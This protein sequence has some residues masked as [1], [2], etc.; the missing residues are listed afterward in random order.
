MKLRKK[1]LITHSN[2]WILDLQVSEKS[3]SIANQQLQHSNSKLADEER[4]I[5]G[6]SGWI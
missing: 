5:S 3:H 4:R 6:G 1:D 2:K